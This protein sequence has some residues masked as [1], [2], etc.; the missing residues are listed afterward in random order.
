MVP[1]LDRLEQVSAADL[2]GVLLVCW[3]VVLAVLF[4]S[5]SDPAAPPRW[6][7]V[8]G[9]LLTLASVV[10]ALVLYRQTSAEGDE[11]GTVWE[12]VPEWEYEGRHGEVNRTARR[13]QEET[14]RE[15]ESGRRNP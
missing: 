14:L 4:T 6:W 1:G 11:L 7:G 15:E 8:A 12:A 9:L 5:G 10:V 13:E 2:V 3:V